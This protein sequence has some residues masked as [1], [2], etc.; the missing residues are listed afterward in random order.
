MSAKKLTIYECDVCGAEV[1]SNKILRFKA[2]WF[3][4]GSVKPSMMKF[5]IC[6]RCFKQIQ[7]DVRNSNNANERL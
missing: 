3:E 1:D 4:L 6:K 5:D 2:S 7:R